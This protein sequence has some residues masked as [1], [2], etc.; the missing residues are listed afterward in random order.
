MPAGSLARKFMQCKR[1]D[2]LCWHFIKKKEFEESISNTSNLWSAIQVH[3]TQFWFFARIKP[4]IFYNLYVNPDEVFLG[5]GCPV[6][7]VLPNVYY[8]FFY[9]PHDCGI[10]T[11]P[12]RG[13]LLLKTKIK[14]ISR[15]SAVRAEMPLSCVVRNQHPLLNVVETRDGE[16]GNEWEIEVKIQIA[17]EDTAV[18]SATQSCKNLTATLP[19][20]SNEYLYC[21]GRN[22]AVHFDTERQFGISAMIA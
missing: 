6:T 12:L 8:E 21:K 1:N 10:V 18:T 17:N 2:A 13:V 7:Y 14:Y 3:C 4:T 16:T 15:D 19:C 20:S 22:C 5:D 9:H 11:Q